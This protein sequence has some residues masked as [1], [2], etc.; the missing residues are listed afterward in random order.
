MFKFIINNIY[1]NIKVL[2]KFFKKNLKFSLKKTHYFFELFFILVSIKTNIFLKKK[3][4]NKYIIRIYNIS[5]IK[6]IFILLI[7]VIVF[8]V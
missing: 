6:K 5:N 3:G 4:C 8:F 2:K 1:K 7:I